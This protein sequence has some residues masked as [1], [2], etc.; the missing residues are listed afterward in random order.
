VREKGKPER[1]NIHSEQ[2]NRTAQLSIVIQRMIVW[3]DIAAD[4]IVSFKA[5]LR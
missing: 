2:Y 4:S 5:T 3:D 1:L